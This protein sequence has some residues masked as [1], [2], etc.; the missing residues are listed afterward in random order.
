MKVITE[1]FLRSAFRKDAFSTFT[2]EPGQILTP[3]AVQF[4]NERKIRIVEPGSPEAPDTREGV[5]KS[6]KDKDGSVFDKKP[7]HMTH[8]TGNRL[9][10]KNHSRIRFRGKLDNL[11]SDILMVQ[12]I[13]FKNRQNRLS[14]DLEEILDRVRMIMK[15]DVLD[16]PLEAGDMLGLSQDQ[17]RARSHTPKKYYGIGHIT[18]C[19]EMGQMLLNLNRL[20]S[21]VRD[22]ELSAVCAYCSESETG[23]MDIIQTLNRMSSAIY[24]MMIREQAGQYSNTDTENQ[25][26]YKK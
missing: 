19:V 8:L 12:S 4:L 3:S 21:R 17:L 11:Q 6:R 20:R 9:V 5:K 7:E 1:V 23:R 24:I 14:Q 13:A 22:V 25:V 26:R 15:A 18:P 16:Q 2:R 10:T